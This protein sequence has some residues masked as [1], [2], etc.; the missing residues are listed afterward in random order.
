MVTTAVEVD[1]A[2]ADMDT[3]A[4]S[5]EA[6]TNTVDTQDMDTAAVDMD[7]EAPSLEAVTNTVNTQDMDMEAAMDTEV[8]NTDTKGTKAVMTTVGK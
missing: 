3:E 6:V 4:P 8:T 1:T 2:A 5:L 7:M